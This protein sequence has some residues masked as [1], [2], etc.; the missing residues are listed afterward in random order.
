MVA[1]DYANYTGFQDYVTALTTPVI[2][3]TWKIV[4]P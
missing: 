3:T 2:K 1:I 4:L